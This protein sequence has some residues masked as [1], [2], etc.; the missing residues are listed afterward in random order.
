VELLRRTSGPS[1]KRNPEHGEGRKKISARKSAQL[2][3]IGTFQ[4]FR[5]GCCDRNGSLALTTTQTPYGKPHKALSA[6]EESLD[7]ATT[8]VHPGRHRLRVRFFPEPASKAAAAPK[9]VAA[10]TG[11]I[12]ASGA[13]LR[14]EHFSQLEQRHPGVFAFLAFTPQRDP[15]VVDYLRAGSLPEDAGSRA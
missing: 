13:S 14:P 6:Q 10:L 1:G 12:L 9:G 8:E 3:E 15:G 4:A 11:T 2:V 5:E 7:E